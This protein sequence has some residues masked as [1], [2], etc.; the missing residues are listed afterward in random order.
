MSEIA[1]R[2]AARYLA[3]GG[4]VTVTLQDSS[5]GPRN[6]VRQTWRVDSPGKSV[7]VKTVTSDGGIDFASKEDF[8]VEAF[9]KRAGVRSL[10]QH[11]IFGAPAEYYPGE[12]ETVEL[13][14]A[15]FEGL[16]VPS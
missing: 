13:D 12:G 11:L 10:I 7:V 5:V 8:V 15:F 1:R 4:A 3:A 16:P 6:R 14:Q 2:V 9:G